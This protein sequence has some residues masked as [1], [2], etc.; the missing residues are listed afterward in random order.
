MTTYRLAN[1]DT[2]VFSA[3]DGV[4][5]TIAFR[6]ADFGDITQASADEVVAALNRSPRLAS[7][8][9]ETGAV[10]LATA[11]KGGHAR[12]EID[13]PASSAAGALG[14]EPRRAAAHGVGLVAARLVSGHHEP[15]PLPAG[16]AMSIVVD[17]RRR[18][19]TFDRGITAGRATA[20]EVSDTINGGTPIARSTTDGR[21]V[22]TSP[23]VG[24]GSSLAVEPGDG[25][26]RP[27]AAA[28]LGFVGPTAASRPYTV[29]P[30]RITCAG[31]ARGMAVVNLTAGPIELHLSSGVVVVP[32]RQQL[33]L[34]SGEVASPTLQRLVALGQVGLVPQA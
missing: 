27:D 30:A 5:E 11:T 34:A 2:L 9:D 4:W 28:I 26:G 18:K 23:T 12:L 19:V 10:T 8:V 25:A 6:A 29:E 13:V 17:G 32:A 24:L 15:F 21:V 1:G 7:F 16:A 20:A 33:P 14:L 31:A 3:D 22:V